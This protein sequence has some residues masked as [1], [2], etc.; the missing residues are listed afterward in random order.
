MLS[1]V[2]ASSSSENSWKNVRSP[3]GRGT[4]TTAT[5][6]SSTRVSINAGS[7][8][9]TASSRLAGTDCGPTPTTEPNHRPSELMS[10]GRSAPPIASSAGGSEFGSSNSRLFT[11]CALKNASWR[12]R[13]SRLSRRYSL[14]SP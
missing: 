10:T 9:S 11:S 5:G 14:D 1:R 13:S 6:T 8:L 4:P 3:S 12:I 7:P 2:R